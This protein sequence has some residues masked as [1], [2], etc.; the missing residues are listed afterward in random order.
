VEQQVIILPIVL[1]NCA[2]R[3]SSDCPTGTMFAD[4]TKVLSDVIWC[5]MYPSISMDMHHRYLQRMSLLSRSDLKYQAIFFKAFV[6]S[7]CRLII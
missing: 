6:A 3:W 7:S 2:Q 5:P 1:P 4:G